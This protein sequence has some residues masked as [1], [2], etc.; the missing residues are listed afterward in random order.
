MRN[1]LGVIGGNPCGARS[2]LLEPSVE[3]P[4]GRDPCEG[5]REDAMRTSLGPYVEFPW[6]HDS[7]QGGGEQLLI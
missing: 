1:C 6:G 3:L 5:G 2:V 7:C 4:M